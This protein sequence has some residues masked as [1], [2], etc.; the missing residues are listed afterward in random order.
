MQDKI[1]KIA[2]W[3]WNNK[4]RMVLVVM[5]GFLV[6]RVWQVV[7]PP[8]PPDEAFLRP[9]MQ[10]LPEEPGPGIQPP[11]PPV[12]PPM[13]IPGDYAAIHQRNPF[14]Y[15]GT[16]AGRGAQAGAADLQIQLLRI[17]EVNNR[18]RAQLRTATT[19]Q[20]YN[21]GERFEE[22]E[23]RSID[24]AENSVTIHSERLGRTITLT[25]GN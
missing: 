3:I 14:W 11:R 7:Y 9:P 23:L 19:T 4:E 18:F 10:S 20:W 24:P 21:E 12:A 25:T 2:A 22:F 17:R 16:Q 5:V 6:Y 13:R 15:F 1:R 8:P